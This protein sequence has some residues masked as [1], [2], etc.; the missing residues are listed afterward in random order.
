MASFTF[1]DRDGKVYPSQSRRLA[2]DFF[3]HAQVYRKDGETVSLQPG[4]YT[5]TYTRGPEYLVLKKDI[6]V[7]SKATHTESFQLKRWVHPAKKGWWSGD[8]HI[9]AAGCSHYESP[10]E[11]VTPGDMMRH[12]LGEDLN[13]GCV[14]SWGPCWYHQKQFFSG[15]VDRL[16]TK[17]YLMR[18]DVEVSGF[19]SQHAGHLCLLRLTEDD[20][21]YPQNVAFDWSFGA[22]RAWGNT[23]RRRTP[24]TIWATPAKIPLPTAV[25]R[26]SS[27]HMDNRQLNAPARIITAPSTSTPLTDVR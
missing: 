24:Q 15:D 4:K 5:V 14:L 13:V 1:R 3:F 11:G 26:A 17:D 8:H 27:S 21:E 7:P 16:S 18:Y 23:A 20:Y 2:P 12:T 9:H 6:T 19:P 22:E 10:T 25:A